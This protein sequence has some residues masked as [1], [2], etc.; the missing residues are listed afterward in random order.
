MSM[1]SG[2][3]GFLLSTARRPREVAQSSTFFTLA[4]TLLASAFTADSLGL[5]GASWTGSASDRGQE[6]SRS[7]LGASIFFCS[8]GFDMTSSGG[9]SCS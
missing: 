3:S 7:W 5:F 4:E 6:Y 2:C 8:V 9:C 1:A